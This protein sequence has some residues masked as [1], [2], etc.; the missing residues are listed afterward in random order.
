MSEP[1]KSNF[2]SW[3]HDDGLYS[4]GCYISWERGDTEATLDGRYTAE[5]LRQVADYME[6]HN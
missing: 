1:R 2:E 3:I 5:E 6:K 4:L